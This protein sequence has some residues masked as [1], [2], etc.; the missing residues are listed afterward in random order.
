[1]IGWIINCAFGG[2]KKHDNA[3]EWWPL[4][5]EIEDVDP[6]EQYRA[7][8]ELLE[9]SLAEQKKRESKTKIEGQK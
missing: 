4:P 8:R 3:E 7:S 6:D 1:M 2:G 5:W 9:K